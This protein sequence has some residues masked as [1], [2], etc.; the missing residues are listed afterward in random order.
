MFSW[1]AFGSLVLVIP[2]GLLSSIV[3]S[4]R[5]FWEVLELE[6]YD[7]RGRSTLV[8]FRVA[9]LALFSNFGPGRWDF[10]GSRV[11]MKI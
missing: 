9:E 3:H 4:V 1:A 5:R 7:R 8:S 6:I 10:S 2:V 11:E